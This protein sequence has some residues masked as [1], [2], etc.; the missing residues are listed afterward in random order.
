MKV[1]FIKNTSLLRWCYYVFRERHWAQDEVLCKIKGEMLMHSY[2]KYVRQNLIFRWL[3]WR[4]LSC[5]IR[6]CGVQSGM[7]SSF[8]C[9]KNVP[10]EV[11]FYVEKHF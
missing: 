5:S 3:L 8:T 4:L 2:I 11:L 9:G 6:G 1:E 7:V 10:V